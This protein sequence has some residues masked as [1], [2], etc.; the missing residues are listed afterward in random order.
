[1][2]RRSP[3]RRQARGAAPGAPQSRRAAIRPPP[4]AAAWV[5]LLAALATLAVYWSTTHFQLLLDD[6]ILFKTSPSLRTLASI[7]RGFVTDLGAVRKGSTTVQGS[8]YRPVFLALST[9]YYQWVGP[10]PGGWHVASVALAAVVAALASWFFRRVGLPPLAALLAALVFALHPSHVSSVAWVSGI[11]EQLAA[12][13]VLVA[14]IALL[15]PVADEHPRRTLAIAV[16]A[17]VCALLSKEVSL[18]LLPMVGVWAFVRRGDQPEESRRFARATAWLG[19]VAVLYLG[20]RL[21]VLGAFARPWAEAPGF[22]RAAPSVPLAFVT[23]VHLLVWP[24]AFSFFR[25]ERP[26]WGPFD[27]PVLVSAAAL[28]ALVAL[29]WFGVKRRPLLLLPLAW[30]VVWL[31][32]V[33]NFWALYPEW[34]VTDRYL[35]LP[36]LALPWALYVLLPRRAA[37]PALA[38]VAVVFALLTVRYAAIFV[39]AKTFSMAMEK[40]EPT[41]SYIVEERARVYLVEGQTAAAEAAY[42]RALTIDPWDADALWKV[43]NFERQR[44][45]FAA[46]RLHYRRAALQAPNDSTPFMTLAYAMAK[47]G[48]RKQALA[49][50]RETEY[51]WPDRFE[52]HLLQS[53]LLADAGDRA[54]AEQ[55]FAAAR[56]VRPQEPILGQGLDHAIAVL[57]PGI[58]L[59][60]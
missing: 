36:S 1:M 18:A 15:S 7:P 26:F 12:L 22:A 58:G 35:Y 40:A 32:P 51:R 19:G 13:F 27:L 4:G 56:R 59:S 9:L 47:G 46:A 11:Q 5:W 42:R 60:N 38:A 33:M 43:G 57:S 54:G 23:Y 34:M 50:L 53:L 25:P 21:A 41:S 39:D 20:V 49:L 48:Q 6:V 30:F 28:L 3:Q 55:A 10:G 24:T 16:G 14:L 45:D 8:F 37:A 31:L 44:G 2:A 52:P 29:A 17:F